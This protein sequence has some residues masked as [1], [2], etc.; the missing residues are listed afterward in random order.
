MSPST[1]RPPA[2][3]FIV[4][5]VVLA[6]MGGGLVIPVLPGLVKHFEGG[7]FAQASH[8][9]G[10]VIL[11]FAVTQFVAAPIL[12]ALSDRFGRR[13]VILITTAGAGVD[14]LLMA[15]APTLAWIFIARMVAGFTAGIIATSNAYLVDVTPPEH[16]A[17]SFGLLGAA[18]GIGF[19]I[20]PVLGGLLGG[21]DLRLPFWAAS[22]L[23]AGNFAYGWFVL[24]ESLPRDRRRAFAWKRANPVGALLNL[25]HRPVVLGLAATHLM[26]WIAQAMLHSN[27]VLYTD[28]R[29][30]WG[31]LQVGLSLCLVGSCS[32]LVQATLVKRILERIGEERGVLAGYAIIMLAHIGY[33]LATRSSMI[34]PIIAFASLGAIAGPALQSYLSRQV[35]ASEQGAVQGAFMALT[36]VGAI[37]GQP[38]A[39]W[40]FGWAVAP[41]NPVH[42][43][44]VAFFEAAV[45]MAAAVATAHHTFRRNSP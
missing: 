6:V 41:D 11:I 35:P 34:Y 13:R 15:L 32:A 2:V 27:W 33:G 9:Y 31:P 36:S 5:T 22:A 30:Q 8:S 16:R 20:G 18:F 7:D 44:G 19:V 17:R 37:I 12:G 43:P 4:V 28:Y 23:A 29:Y 38:I 45:L 42:L 26:F 40:S 39:A 1:T 24:P 25:R 21:I 10:W 14:Y 3:G